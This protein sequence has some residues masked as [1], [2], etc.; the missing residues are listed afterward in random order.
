MTKPPW[1]VYIVIEQHRVCRSRR[2]Y[3]T[4]CCICS[5][6]RPIIADRHTPA[7]PSSQVESRLPWTYWYISGAAVLPIYK[8]CFNQDITD[9]RGSWSATVQIRP[10]RSWPLAV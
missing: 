3:L 5:I 7:C 6:T 2:F 8:D 10:L 1:P 9:N 4:S